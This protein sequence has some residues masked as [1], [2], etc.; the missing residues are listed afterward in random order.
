LDKVWLSRYPHGVPEEI[1]PEATVGSLLDLFEDGFRR[2]AARPAYCNMGTTVTYAQVDRMSQAFAAYLQQDLG[3]EKG[4][5]IALMMPNLLQ[6]PVALIG[7]LRAGLAIVNV[8]P[9]YTPRELEHQLKDSGAVAIVILAHSAQVLEK[10]LDHTPVKHVIVTRVGD[11]FPPIKRTT[12]NLVLRWV[13]KMEPAWSIPRAARFREAISRGRERSLQDV[14]MNGEDIA[15]LQYTGG[16]TGVAKGAVLTHRNMV[17]NVQQVYSWFRPTLKEATEVVVTPL[18][19]YHIFSLTANFLTFFRFGA[20]N[21]LI[22]NPKDISTFV[23]ALAS[24]KFTVM[25]GVNT[26]FNALLNSPDFHKLD[27]SSFKVCVGGGMALHRSVAEEWKRVTGVPLAEGYG[28][29][30]ASPVVAVNRLDIDEY[31]GSVGMPLPS[32]EISIRDEEGREMALGEPGELWIRGPQVM[33][34]YWERPEETR[35]VLTADGWLKS[36]DIARVEREGTIR[37][38]DRKKDMI[39]VS[40]FNVYPNEIEAIVIGHECVLE[41]AAVGVPDRK[42]GEAVKICVVK[43]DPNLDA[44]TLKA[45]CREKLAGYKVPKYIEFRDELPKSSV[46]KILRRLLRDKPN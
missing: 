28:L 8:N 24:M 10:I 9:L 6:Y 7:A 44:D 20:L 17:A 15:I 39:L 5:R 22:T 23:E 19:L 33:R 30:E 34:G 1:G 16:T 32:T 26:L 21:L 18:P 40:G 37:L 41:V 27:F 36:G 46:G 11:L 43:K 45:F 2:F 14:K 29:T 42:S 4:S 13:K 12:V 35:M 3:L 31:N 25:T 38:V